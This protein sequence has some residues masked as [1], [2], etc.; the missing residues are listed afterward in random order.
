[1]PVPSFFRKVLAAPWLDGKMVV[2]LLSLIIFPV[3]FTW[4]SEF[5][6][7]EKRDVGLA[8]PIPTFPVL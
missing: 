5:G 6:P 8:F 7:A 2:I 3:E 1:M 4:N